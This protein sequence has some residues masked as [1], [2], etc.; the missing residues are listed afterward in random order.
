M[1]W[2]PCGQ[3]EASTHTFWRGRKIKEDWDPTWGGL[4]EICGYETPETGPVLYLTQGGDRG[5]INTSL[6]VSRK[7]TTRAWY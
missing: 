5:R 4:K 2:R 1:C 7:T 6:V 3:V